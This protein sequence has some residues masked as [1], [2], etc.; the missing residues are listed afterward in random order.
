MDRRS[1]LRTAAASAGTGILAVS[2]AD[3]GSSDKNAAPS[4]NQVWV[5][6]ISL[7]RL[8][9]KTMPEMVDRVIERMKEILPMSPDIFCIPEV[10]A[11]ERVSQKPPF[12][13][14]AE[15][16]PGEIVNRFG[17]F[18]KEHHC[19]VICPLHTKEGDTIYNS[20]VLIDRNGGVVG[21]YHKIHPTISEIEEGVTSGPLDPPVFKTDFGTI[22]IQICFD[23]N[24]YPAWQ[25]MRKK[26]AEVIFWPSAFPGGRMLNA[27][28]W[29]NK[30]Y[31][32]TSTW[33]DPTRIIDI[34]GNEIA[35]SGR[36]EYWVCAPINLEKTI[37][38]IWPYGEKL[39]RLKDKYG[40]KIRIDKLDVEGWGV[41]ESVSPDLP[42][43]EALREFEIPTHEEHIQAAHAA[44]EKNRPIT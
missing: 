28:A 27:Q 17:A 3:A 23:V 35:G 14:Q 39:A 20:A 30:T 34:T 25:L 10:F 22:G 5:A 6:S 33:E 7:E 21:A 36:Y 8:Q 9:G 26:G 31:I 12:R 13:E 24:W 15:T 16:V 11:Y 29:M 18:A 42:V 32:V 38:H 40:R 44:Q 41:V 37:V 2:S 4:R 1:F 43:L 19:Y